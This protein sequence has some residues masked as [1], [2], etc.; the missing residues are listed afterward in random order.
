MRHLPNLGKFNDARSDLSE[1]VFFLYV[2]PQDAFEDLY[3]S[4]SGGGFSV[5]LFCCLLKVL[6]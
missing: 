6:K 5:K 1:K 4:K 3:V 2:G